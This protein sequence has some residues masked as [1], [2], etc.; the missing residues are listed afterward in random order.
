MAPKNAN[1]QFVEWAAL[2]TG[3]ACHGHA[4]C[5]LTPQFFL[6]HDHYRLP[7]SVEHLTP[8]L[9]GYAGPHRHA[10]FIPLPQ[11]ICAVLEIAS[12][13]LF[14]PV[15][16]WIHHM[17]AS[18][19]SLSCSRVPAFASATLL[20]SVSKWIRIII[21]VRWLPPMFPQNSGSR[22]GQ[23]AWPI[24]GLTTRVFHLPPLLPT[25][26]VIEYSDHVVFLFHPPHLSYHLPAPLNDNS[27]VTV[28]VVSV[29]IV[30][31]MWQ[32]SLNQYT[33][34]VTRRPHTPRWV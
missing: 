7:T 14:G 5:T 20:G 12:S 1:F 16:M 27:I 9:R 15:S 28:I 21:H 2:V 30:L 19:N 17:Y 29:W 25:P 8:R 26:R 18:A 34:F 24:T 3:D 13:T 11:R 6:G 32:V 10:G 4:C 23:P 31:L 33:R 22:P